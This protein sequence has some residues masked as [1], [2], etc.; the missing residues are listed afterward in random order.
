MNETFLNGMIHESL[1]KGFVN[2]HLK[3]MCSAKNIPKA[4]DLLSGSLSLSSIETLRSVEYLKPR[5]CGVMPSAGQ[6]RN[7]QNILARC[8]NQIT[9][10]ILEATESGESTTFN[11]SQ[12]LTVMISTHKLEQVAKNLSL[13]F[14]TT[15]DSAKI[16]NNTHQVVVGFKFVDVLA[17]DP[18]AV[19]L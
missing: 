18:L 7:V 13:I 1:H 6:L 10:L 15:S 19:N 2:L 5:V 17:V 11:I 14:A 8:G 16:T 9:P 12:L 4:M 3:N